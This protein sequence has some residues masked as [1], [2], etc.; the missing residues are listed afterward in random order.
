MP[1]RDLYAAIDLGSNSFHLV[2]ARHEHGELRVIDQLK[3][4]VRIAGGLN[5]Q[6]Q[7]DPSTSEH[8]LASLSRF[9]ERIQGIPADHIR[10]VGTQTF[11][12]LAQRDAFLTA[13]E[14]ALGAPIEVIGGREEARLIYI[15]VCQGMANEG[16]PKLIIDVGGGSTEVVAGHGHTP[17]VLESLP[18]GCVGLTQKF[19]KDH[20]ISASRWARGRDKVMADAQSL[21]AQIK[22]YPWQQAIGASGTARALVAMADALHPTMPSGLTRE[23]MSEIRERLIQAKR[24]DAIDLPGL[25]ERRRP[26]IAGGALIIDGLM[27]A[28]SIDVL[29]ASPFALREGLLYDLVARLAPDQGQDNPRQ[30][31]IEAMLDRYQCDRAQARRVRHWALT[32]WDATATAWSLPAVS[33]ELLAATCSVHELGLAIAHEH[34]HLHSG[35]VL[36]HA[37]MPGFSQTEQQVMATLARGQRAKPHPGGLDLI[38]ERLHETTLHLLMLMRLAVALARARNDDW[39]DRIEWRA[40]TRTLHLSLPDAWLK[41]HP[42]THR[43]L[44]VEADQIKRL[45]LTLTIETTTA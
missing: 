20:D 34:Y 38:P 24:L 39:P 44:L 28:L 15:G 10:A 37:D 14:K 40:D 45:S 5:R 1:K 21:A 43:D 9:R 3:D 8:A 22:T 23:R 18:M 29:S 27:D 4:M 25:S 2:V 19:F 16:T 17:S 36:A 32:G 33:R 13:A 12:R 11:R 35:Y 7:L 6:G 31:T 26:V 41:A 42:L 30:G